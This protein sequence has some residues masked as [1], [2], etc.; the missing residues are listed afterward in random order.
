MHCK[1][2]CRELSLAQAAGFW[3]FLIWAISASVSAAPDY[4]FDNISLEHGLSQSS[5]FGLAED[6]SGHLW[7]ATEQ[8]LDRFDGFSVETLRYQPGSARSL[9]HSGVRA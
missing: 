8:G 9:T 5:V 7:V 3:F 2:E 6:P 1:G 4:R